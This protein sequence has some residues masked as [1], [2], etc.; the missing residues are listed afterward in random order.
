MRILETKLEG[1]YTIEPET[2]G[3]ERGF[4]ARTF[5]KKELAAA[6]LDFD[7]VQGNMT[8]TK[9]KGTVRGMHF[10][11]IPMAEK[12]MVQCVQGEV[13]DVAIDLREESETYGSW[14]GQI[15]SR[16]NR[17]IFFI[18]E[19][20]AHGFQ[21]LADNCVLSYL[22]SEFYSPADASGVR[23]DDPFF[24]IKWPTKDNFLSEKDKRWPLITVK[25]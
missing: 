10:Q 18:P 15:L 21:T 20:F 5:C 16:E 7:V 24:N 12:K 11:K 13:Y 14:V 3:D 4:F 8:F 9:K 19:G 1:L 25:K 2:I 17:K 23:W 6:G 22:M